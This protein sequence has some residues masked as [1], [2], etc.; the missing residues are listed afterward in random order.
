MVTDRHEEVVVIT[1]EIE[2]H[3]PILFDGSED[4]AV[5]V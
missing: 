5:H 3:S 2:V 1:H 4:A